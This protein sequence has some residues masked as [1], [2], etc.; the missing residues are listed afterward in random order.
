MIED[1]IR[2]LTRLE[3]FID[4]LIKPET[5]RWVDWTPTLAQLGAVT[6]TVTV[7]R[8]EAKGD[9]VTVE[10]RLDV[11]SAGTVGNPVVIGGVPSA[12]APANVG[13]LNVIGN[14][15]VYD[16]GTMAYEGS[17]VAVGVSDWRFITNGVGNYVGITPNFALASG[18]V[19]S[20]RATYK[21]A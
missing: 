15:M 4:G 18:D 13:N 19:I 8:Y 16:T 3:R 2:R 5:G 12:I 9:T 14:G 17:L 10:V 1:V 6:V 7:A 11:T 20:F 21:R